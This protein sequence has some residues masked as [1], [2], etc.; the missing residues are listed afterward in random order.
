MIDSHCHLEQSVYKDRNKLIKKYKNFGLKA[1]ITSCAHP[2]DF[3]L[4]MQLVNQYKKFVF[5]TVGIHPEYVKDLSDNQ[6]DVFIEKIKNY[7]NNIVGIGEIGLDYFWVKEPSL[8]E[9]QKILFE[10]MLD[11]ANTLNKPIIIHCRE[12]YEDTL[13]LLYDQKNVLLHMWGG[14]KQLPIVIENNWS[15]SINAIILRSKKHKKIIRDM[16]LENIMLETDAPWLAPEKILEGKDVIND[17]T[18]VKTVANKIAEIKKIDVEQVIEQTTKN[19]I[20]FFN[21]PI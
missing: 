4:T 19:A 5:A 3:N 6:I 10:K 16:P 12:A 2:H 11:L 15:I 1:I 7:Q 20:N 14:W 18:T 9:K 8:I 17:S 13:D 21:L